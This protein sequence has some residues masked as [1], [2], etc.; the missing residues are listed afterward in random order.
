MAQ[1]LDELER[2]LMSSQG[3]NTP[4]FLKYAAEESGNVARDGMFSIQVHSPYSNT[5]PSVTCPVS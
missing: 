5:N 2:R 4:D 1:D 3:V